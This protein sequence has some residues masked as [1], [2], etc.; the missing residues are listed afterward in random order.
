MRH[1]FLRSFLLG[2]GLL[3]LNILL[4]GCGSSSGSSDTVQ[5]PPVEAVPADAPV[6]EPP[7]TD[8]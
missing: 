3:G 1:D 2:G 7:S 8:E 5:P 4:A 6:N